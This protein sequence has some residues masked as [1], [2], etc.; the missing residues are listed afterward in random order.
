MIVL[1][2]HFGVQPDS[3]NQASQGQ[4]GP[5]RQE[6]ESDL[7]LI[8]YMAAAPQVIFSHQKGAPQKQEQLYYPILNGG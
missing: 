1:L 4:S 2:K 8:F 6:A 3:I 7:D 5:G